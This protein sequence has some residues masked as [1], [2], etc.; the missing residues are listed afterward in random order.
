MGLPDPEESP[1]KEVKREKYNDAKKERTKRT[2]ALREDTFLRLRAISFWMMR[3]E[4]MK[5]STVD[6]VVNLGIEALLE[7][8]PELRSYVKAQIL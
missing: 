3:K 1:K 2:V 5:R 6:D 8:E 7:S 4:R